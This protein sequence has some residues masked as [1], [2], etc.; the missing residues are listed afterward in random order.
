MQLTALNTAM[1]IDDMDIPGF[2][3]HPLKGGNEVLHYLHYS[4]AGNRVRH[5]PSRGTA[6][7][8]KVK[9]LLCPSRGMRLKRPFVGK[10]RVCG[11]G[12]VSRSD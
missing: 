2:Q 11:I 4:P 7:G 6:I 1:T 12:D 9:N 10:M 3:L 8:A 5:L